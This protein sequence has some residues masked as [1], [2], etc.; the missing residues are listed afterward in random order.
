ML[1]AVVPTM[2]SALAGIPA[3]LACDRVEPAGE[4]GAAHDAP[5]AEHQSDSHTPILTKSS[6]RR[7]LSLLAAAPIV[8]TLF[9]FEVL[10]GRPLEHASRNVE[11]RAVAWAVPRALGRRSSFTWQP[12]C[13]H[14]GETA[15]SVPSS[16]R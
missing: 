8:A 6:V 5:G 3:G 15:C 1:P 13:V 4:P 16:S 11:A 7:C 10:H 12:R 9:G 2:Y 14:T